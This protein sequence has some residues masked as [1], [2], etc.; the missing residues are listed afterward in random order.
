MTVHE[1]VATPA[2]RDQIILRVVSEIA[3]PLHVMNIQVRRGSAVLAAPA[4]S[5]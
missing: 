1:S 3:P 2:Q 4:V 5:L